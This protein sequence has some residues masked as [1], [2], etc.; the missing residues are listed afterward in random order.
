MHKFV[1][2]SLIGAGVLLT[3]IGFGMLEADT[4]GA[5]LGALTMLL[6]AG[7]S[8]CLAGLLGLSGMMGWVPGLALPAATGNATK[9]EFSQK[10]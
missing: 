9:M 8:A 3:S 10:I 4:S 1:W 5:S 6:T 7:L 2:I